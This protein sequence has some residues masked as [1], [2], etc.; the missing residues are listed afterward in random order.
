MNRSKASPALV[1]LLAAYISLLPVV[2]AQQLTDKTAPTIKHEPLSEPLPLGE[3]LAISATVTDDI[4]VKS[5]LLFY[6]TRGRNAYQR[7]PMQRWGLATE[8]AAAHSW[9]LSA[10]ASFVTGAHL[11]V[12][13]G[14][15]ANT[16]Q[17]MPEP[18]SL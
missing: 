14:I 18:F 15:S 17:F 12:D 3:N 10:K 1:Y 6:R 11:P 5:V 2:Q 16:G 4:S 13:G 9:L 7:V 8:L